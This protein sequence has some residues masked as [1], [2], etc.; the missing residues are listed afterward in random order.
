MDTGLLKKYAVTPV[1][2][3]IGASGAPPSWWLS[4]ATESIYVGFD[5]DARDFGEDSA[6]IFERSH[7][8][9]KAV[10]VVEQDSI[11]FYLT[12]SPYC[13]STLHPELDSLRSL[14]I[15]ICSPFSL[16]PKSS[17]QP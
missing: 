17:R 2:V 3:D 16:R 8:I 11:T 4:I 15:R 5:P 6:S 9:G 10:T 14:A 12:K 13:S 7:I 1:L